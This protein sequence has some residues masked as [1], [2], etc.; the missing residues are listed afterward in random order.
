MHLKFFDLYFILPVLKSSSMWVKFGH[1]AASS[2]RTVCVIS[3]IG[4]SIYRSDGP[5][6][7]DINASKDSREPKTNHCIIIFLLD[8]V[9]YLLLKLFVIYFRFLVTIVPYFLIDGVIIH[10]WYK[11]KVFWCKYIQ[12]FGDIRTYM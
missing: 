9:I 1:F 7:I 2:C 5:N 6:L 11:I 8:G 3:S 4:S 12:T 10:N